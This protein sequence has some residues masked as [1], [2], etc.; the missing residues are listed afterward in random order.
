V[1]A[2][3]RAHVTSLGGN[4]LLSY[5]MSQCVLL[6]NPHKNQAQC[7]VNVG[8]DAVLVGHSPRADE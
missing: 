3:V 1:L 8:G 6:C 5:F 4:A 2:V 7:L